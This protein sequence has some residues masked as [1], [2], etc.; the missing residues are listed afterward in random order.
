MGQCTLL[1]TVRLKVRKPKHYI[2]IKTKT[3]IEKLPG[4]FVNC[5]RNNGENTI[6]QFYELAE[7]MGGKIEGSREKDVRNCIECICKIAHVCVSVCGGQR[8]DPLGRRGGPFLIAFTR[9]ELHLK[10]PFAR[11]YFPGYARREG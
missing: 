11:D 8:R 2:K 5:N 3:N 1:Y 6:M 10:F 4:G 7:R 9:P